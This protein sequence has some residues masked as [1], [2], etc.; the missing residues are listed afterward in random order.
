MRGFA[1]IGLDRCKS[2]E[3]LGGVLR[4]AG[5]Y[6]ASLVNLSGGRMGKYITDTMHAYKQIPC[7]EVADLMS[8]I[9]YA[10]VPVVIELHPRAISLAT[11]VHPESAYYIFG[12]EDGS[13]SASIVERAPLVVQVPTNRCMN[14]AAT[15]N[16]VLYDRLMKQLTRTS[17]RPKVATTT[18]KEAA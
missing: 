11:F 6:G 1:A 8:V 4:A 12:P 17:V 9:P 15:V 5:C 16:V 13:V 18:T 14:L 10:A 7:L 3:N 2:K